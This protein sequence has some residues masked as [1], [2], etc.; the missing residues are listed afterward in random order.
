[1]VTEAVFILVF[2]TTSAG[3]AIEARFEQNFTSKKECMADRE[4]LLEAHRQSF[5]PGL[6]EMINARCKPVKR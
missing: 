1:V 4:R 3:S 5:P 2:S 6:G